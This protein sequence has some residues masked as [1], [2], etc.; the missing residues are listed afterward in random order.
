MSLAPAELWTGHR[1]VATTDPPH[2]GLLWITHKELY[3]RAGLCGYMQCD[4]NTR[5]TFDIFYLS[6]PSSVLLHNAAAAISSSMV[7]LVSNIQGYYWCVNKALKR[8]DPL[9]P[10]NY[11]LYE[12]SHGSQHPS[13]W[14][15]CH[16]FTPEYRGCRS[17]E[18]YS[19]H[20]LEKGLRVK[21]TALSWGSTPQYGSYPLVEG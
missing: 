14:Q 19:G 17:G 4:I 12:R 21:I 13:R 1:V 6:Q 5:T 11:T 2:I 7:L 15:L 18:S 16:N 9:M 10:C 20:A 3:F 8:E